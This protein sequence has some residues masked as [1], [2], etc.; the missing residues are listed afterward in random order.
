MESPCCALRIVLIRPG[1]EEKC[2][3][4]ILCHVDKKRKV[5]LENVSLEGVEVQGVAG[6]LMNPG[7]AIECG[8]FLLQHADKTGEKTLART[9][10]ENFVE[11]PLAYG[12]EKKF[13]GIMYFLDAGGR[14]HII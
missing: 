10:I 3:K 1:L 14:N 5:V 7:H 2:I 9:A 8:W 12:W 6:R 13:G 4:E 11:T